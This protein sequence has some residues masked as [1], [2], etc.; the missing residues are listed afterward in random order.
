MQ[1]QSSHSLLTPVQF[2]ASLPPNMND[3]ELSRLLSFFGINTYWGES[4][5]E[6]KKAVKKVHLVMHRA[7]EYDCNSRAVMYRPKAAHSI[8]DSESNALKIHQDGMSQTSSIIP[9]HLIR[10]LPS[11]R[12]QLL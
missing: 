3:E 4:S 2:P 1:S 10:T 7:A 11:L 9:A 6:F 8:Y 12:L 5:W